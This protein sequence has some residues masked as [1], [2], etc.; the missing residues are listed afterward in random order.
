MKI[1]NGMHNQ[2]FVYY[3]DTFWNGTDSVI[4][5]NNNLID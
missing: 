5:L 3:S 1:H 2:I 4:I